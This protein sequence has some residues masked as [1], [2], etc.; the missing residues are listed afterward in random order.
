MRPT[1]EFATRDQLSEANSA[2]RTRALIEDPAER[3]IALMQQMH[4]RGSSSMAI[5]DAVRG[6]NF[7]I[8]HETVHGILSRGAD[9]EAA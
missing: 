8:S 4:A 7:R 1:P 2:G 3:A 9:A 6:R 5:R